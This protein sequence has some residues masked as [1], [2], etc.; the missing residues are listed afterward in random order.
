MFDLF[1]S[2]IARLRSHVARQSTLRLLLSTQGL[3]ACACYRA[4]NCLHRHRLPPV[5]SHALFTLYHLWWKAVQITTGIWIAPECAIGPGLY[6]GHFDQIFLH[7]DVVIGR[8]CNI[9]Q[10]VTLGLGRSGGVWGVPRIGD[11]VYIASGAKVI[12]PIRVAD[13]T[14]VGATAVVTHDTEEN[15]VVVGVPART[16]SHEGSE[17]YIR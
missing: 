3:W 4:G 16:I 1:R 10:G 7:P 9:S 2:D 15:A 11:R 17:E 12:G 14:V 8:D 6:I 13:G 5:L